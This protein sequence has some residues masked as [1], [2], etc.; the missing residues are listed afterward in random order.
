MCVCVVGSDLTAGTLHA[1]LVLR[2]E[3]SEFE[4]SDLS[5]EG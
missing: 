1:V 3:Y 4:Q 5:E 2:V